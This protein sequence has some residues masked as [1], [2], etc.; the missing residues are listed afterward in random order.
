MDRSLQRREDPE[1]IERIGPY[2]NA[3]MHEENEH[4]AC[5]I[6]RTEEPGQNILIEI[7]VTIKRTME[8]VKNGLARGGSG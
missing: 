2:Y 1:K 6:P 4:D 8:R 7:E 3:L 5:D